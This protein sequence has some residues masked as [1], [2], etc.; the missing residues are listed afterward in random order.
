MITAAASDPQVESLVSR[1]TFNIGSYLGVPVLLGDNQ[2]FGTLCVLDPKP[3][4]F[5]ADDLDLLIIVS[6][7]LR[8]YLERDR[9][10]GRIT[11]DAR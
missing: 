11:F 10:A 7:W 5:S 2:L 1:T 8:L 6:A 9:L 4:Q 3:H